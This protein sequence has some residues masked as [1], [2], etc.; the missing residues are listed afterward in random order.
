[1][2]VR[3]FPGCTLKTTAK[4][5]DRQARACAAALGITLIEP[6]NWQCCGGVFVTADDEIA[7]KLACVR[8]LVDARDAGQPLVTV[9]SACH[10]V[11]KQTNHAIKT[12]SLF[13]DRV[14]RYLGLDTPYAGETQV[15]HFLELLR[16]V[17]GFDAVRARVTQPLTGQRIA[18]YYGCL[19]LRPSAVMQMDDPEN[20]RILEDLLRA[21]GAEP[22]LFP[23]RN[24][25]C[26]GYVALEDPESAA[27]KSRLVQKS[28]GR[29][30]AQ[31]LVTACPLCRYNLTK[32][33]D[34][35]LPT[36]YFTTL[37]AEAFDL[38]GEV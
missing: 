19:L 11:L 3:Y 6:E 8:A 12:D 16:D 21:L 1:M 29:R 24:E 17:V 9:C 22:V 7:S 34:G 30:N 26:G 18:A 20:P 28:A 37:L 5:L 13:A 4:E 15:L 32:H 10:N 14:N 23:R 35:T 33:D 2:N 31:Q 36:V 38:K 25:C 27:K